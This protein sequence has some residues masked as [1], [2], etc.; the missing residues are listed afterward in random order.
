M[1]RQSMGENLLAT[2]FEDYFSD[3]VENELLVASDARNNNISRCFK[4]G[5]FDMH[6]IHSLLDVTFKKV[7]VPLGIIC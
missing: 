1:G 5:Y 2:D 6:N 3:I 7:F 4:H